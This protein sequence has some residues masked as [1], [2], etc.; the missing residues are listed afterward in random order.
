MILANSGFAAITLHFGSFKISFS[1]NDIQEWFQEWIKLNLWKTAFR[2]F[3]LV[4]FEILC[5]R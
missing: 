3:H 2:K 4:H 5:P 1:L